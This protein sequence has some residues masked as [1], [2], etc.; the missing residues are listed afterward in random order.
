MVWADEFIQD[1]APSGLSRQEEF[2]NRE[3]KMS[4][5]GVDLRKFGTKA[6]SGFK[7]SSDPYY[8]RKQVDSMFD[9]SPTP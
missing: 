1:V 5:N 4:V 6:D 9:V 8:G 7:P 2:D 3:R